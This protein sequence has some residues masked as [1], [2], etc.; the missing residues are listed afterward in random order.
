MTEETR[1]HLG[2]VIGVPILTTATLALIVLTVWLA[3][4]GWFSGL[5]DYST[6]R[7][8]YRAGATIAGLFAAFALVV[9]TAAIFPFNPAFH[10]YHRVTGSVEEI[11]HRLVAAGEAGMAERYVFVIDG[12]P[13]GVDDTRATLVEVG[14]KVDL[15]CSL[16]WQYA[17]ESGLACQWGTS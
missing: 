1:W 14:D 2:Y 9:T 15:W 16:E 12:R 8:D 6:D 7:T 5:R 10:Q 13:Y 4:R 11:D 17:G 3:R